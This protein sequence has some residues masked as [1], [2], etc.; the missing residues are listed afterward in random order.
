MYYIFL[1][2]G[3]VLHR[4]VEMCADELWLKA[5]GKLDSRLGEDPRTIPYTI[6]SLCVYLLQLRGAVVWTDFSREG[7]IRWRKPEE[8]ARTTNQ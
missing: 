4:A 1:N 7:R 6:F 5:G 3:L 2:Q 8:Q